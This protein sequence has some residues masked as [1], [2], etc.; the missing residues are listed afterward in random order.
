M[1]R[2]TGGT[3]HDHSS[4]PRKR[5][6]VVSRDNHRPGVVWRNLCRFIP[7]R[8]L[9]AINNAFCYRSHP[10]AGAVEVWFRLQVISDTWETIATVPVVA[11]L[12]WESG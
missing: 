4:L 9:Q 12:T 10:E 6:I 8:L 1:S 7:T 2:D 11:N 3:P 5:G